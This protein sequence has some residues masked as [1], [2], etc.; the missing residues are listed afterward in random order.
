MMA[1]TATKCGH[2]VTIY[3]YYYS[4]EILVSITN[5]SIRFTCGLLKKYIGRGFTLHVMQLEIRDE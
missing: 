4:L 3:L 5:Q 2:R 1:L